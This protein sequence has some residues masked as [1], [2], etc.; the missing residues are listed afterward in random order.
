M[1][2]VESILKYQAGDGSFPKAETSI[3][4]SYGKSLLI[5]ATSLALL[6]MLRIDHI[7][8]AAPI[9]SAIDFLLNKM[10]GGYFEST[11]ATILA[12][13]ALVEFLKVSKSSSER[14]QFDVI[15]NGSPRMITTGDAMKYPDQGRYFAVIGVTR[16]PEPAERDQHKSDTR[17]N[18][19]SANQAP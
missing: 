14:S 16:R 19:I 5:E 7:K 8:F 15:L 17:A 12:M 2:A 4:R 6:S 11:Q 1:K 13:R 3:T 10:N 9:K 18:S